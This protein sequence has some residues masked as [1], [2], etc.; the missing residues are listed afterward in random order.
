MVQGWVQEEKQ[1]RVSTAKAARL[2]PLLRR[3]RLRL[4]WEAMRCHAAA[5]RR[6]MQLLR[7]L[8]S[9]RIFMLLQQAFGEFCR[10]ACCCCTCLA[11]SRRPLL[12]EQWLMCVPLIADSD[13]V[14]L[15]DPGALRANFCLNRMH[16]QKALDA[17]EDSK[18]RTVR[19][20]LSSWGMWVRRRRWAFL[21]LPL[22]LTLGLIAMTSS[23]LMLPIFDLSGSLGI[24]RHR[25][26]A[27]R[28]RTGGAMYRWR[29]LVAAFA[30]W[31]LL[32]RCRGMQRARQ[33]L[34][35]QFRDAALQARA[36]LAWRQLHY[37]L[38][39]LRR[40]MLQPRTAPG[41]SSNSF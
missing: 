22:W 28:A 17:H 12:P 38:S 4:G 15:C 13:S 10:G 8:R 27:E 23:V 25:H 31:A 21:A 18:C 3:L 20:S 7:H 35:G 34:A 9:C 39:L 24:M 41:T 11:A 19:C 36:L 29:L 40:S 16:M 2:S 14:V 5:A 32:Q 1:L 37:R 26:L 6:R 33:Q 30:H